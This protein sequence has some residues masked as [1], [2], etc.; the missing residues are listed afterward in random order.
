MQ[1]RVLLTAVVVVLVA[2]GVGSALKAL[3][4]VP[5]ASVPAPPTVTISIEE[6]HRQVDVK[7]LPVLEVREP[8]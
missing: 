7:S 5:L 4:L 1:K 6:I 2:V 3:T 8:F